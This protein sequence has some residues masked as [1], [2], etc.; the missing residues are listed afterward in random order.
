MSRMGEWSSPRLGR[1]SLPVSSRMRHSD[2]RT[3]QRVAGAR[4]TLDHR[5]SR[6]GPRARGPLD[7]LRPAG[8]WIRGCDG[9]P[10]ATTRCPRDR[11][12][13]SFIAIA[14]RRGGRRARGATRHRRTEHKARFTLRRGDGWRGRIRTFN[15]LIQSQ[16]PYRLATRQ[17][18][19]QDTKSPLCT[20]E[21]DLP[22][23][24][25]G[26]ADRDRARPAVLPTGNAAAEQVWSRTSDRPS[27]SAGA[28]NG[29]AVRRPSPLGGRS[30]TEVPIEALDRP[31]LRRKS[32]TGSR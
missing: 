21:S 10:V 1:G 19:A 5:R 24:L 30:T 9:R 14:K 13:R 27:E 28:W 12:G 23:T 32:P 20:P 18:E 6:L 7:Q 8:R 26:S 15:P 25:P 31:L 16:V 17:R 11:P 2:S 3:R 4:Q 22:R 29:G